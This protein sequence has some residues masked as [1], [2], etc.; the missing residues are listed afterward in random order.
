L[1]KRARRDADL[2]AGSHLRRTESRTR[3]GRTQHAVAADLNGEPRV[4]AVVTGEDVHEAV[5]LHGLGKSNRAHLL[6]P[7]TWTLA[8]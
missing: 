3:V 7:L 8:Q 2:A 1:R 6:P 4:D 5:E